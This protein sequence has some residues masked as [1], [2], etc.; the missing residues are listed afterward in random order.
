[1]RRGLVC[2]IN[3]ITPDIAEMIQRSEA[4]NHQTTKTNPRDYEPQEYNDLMEIFSK[5]EAAE[6][7]PHHQDVV[8]MTM[9]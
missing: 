2:N 5:E 1:M 9:H 6:L 3:A 4:G 7:P 8:R